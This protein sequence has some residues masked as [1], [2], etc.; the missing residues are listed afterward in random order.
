MADLGLFP[1]GFVLH[2]G[3]VLAAVLAVRRLN[4]GQCDNVRQT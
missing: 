3:L 4:L 2:G 1:F